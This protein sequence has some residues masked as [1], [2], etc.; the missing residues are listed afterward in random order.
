MVIIADGAIS[1]AGIA[2][3]AIGGTILLGVIGAAAGIVVKIIYDLFTG[4]I[5]YVFK[6]RSSD[7]YYYVE[8]YYSTYLTTSYMYY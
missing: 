3:G 2:G 4:I 8:P 6:R 1:G 7:G 5:K